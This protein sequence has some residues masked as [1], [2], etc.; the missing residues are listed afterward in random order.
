MLEPSGRFLKG[1]GNGGGGKQGA[2]DVYSRIVDDF[3][4]RSDGVASIER[5]IG[6]EADPEVRREVRYMADRVAFAREMLRFEPESALQEAAL[7]SHSRRLILNCNR[8][9]GKSTISAIRALHRAWFWR[10][11]LILIVSQSHAKAGELLIKIRSFLPELGVVSAKGDGVNRLSIKLPNGSRIVA[12]PGGEKPTRSYSKAAM[13]IVDEAAMVAD[14]VIDAVIPTLARL[15]GDLTMLSTP[16]G[17]RG[18]FYRAWKYGGDEWERVFGPVSESDSRISKE[19]LE[20]ERRRGGDDYYAQEYGCEFLD[21]DSHLFGDDALQEVFSQ[22]LE[23]W[24]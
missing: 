6:L 5:I 18:A 4:R 13:V 8:Q 12:L 14:P 10:E 23:S 9:W 2:L 16:R 1:P 24:E 19:Y 7:R 20:S 3:R 21:R 11:S 22:D 17:K 15:N